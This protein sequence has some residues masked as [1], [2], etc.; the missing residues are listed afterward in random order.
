MSRLKSYQICLVGGLIALAILLLLGYANRDSLVGLL[1]TTTITRYY[2]LD[3]ETY[4]L[5]EIDPTAPLAK[6][7]LRHFRLPLPDLGND[8]PEGVAFIA[9]SDIQQFQLWNLPPSDHGGYF[10]VSIQQEGQFYIFDVPL[11]E[12]QKITRPPATLVGQFT[13]PGLKRDA[14]AVYYAPAELWAVSAKDEQ[15]Y[16]VKLAPGQAVESVTVFDVA[17]LP[18]PMTDVEGFTMRGDGTAFLADDQQRLIV[19]YDNFPDCLA[20]QNCERVWWQKIS[21]R[22]PS[23]LA[24]DTLAQKLVVVDDRGELFYLSDDG[25]TAETILRTNYNLEGVTIRHQTV[26]NLGYNISWLI[27]AVR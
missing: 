20:P 5:I 22:E 17:R 10:V 11:S 24:W 19:R 7:E 27:L 2:L 21:P 14:S 1:P 18:Y 13:I 12:N 8:G 3:E 16:R 26:V 23:D 25:L 15:I 6:R 4:R 9:N